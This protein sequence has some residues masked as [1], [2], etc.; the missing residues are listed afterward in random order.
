MK[1]LYI[2][3]KFLTFPG[4]Y[5]RSFWE[6]LICRCIKVT[7][8]PTGYLRADEACGHV[9]HGLAKKPFGAYILA[10]LPGFLTF[11]MGLAFFLLGFMNLEY[12]GI[13]FYDSKP[14]FIAYAVILYLGISLLCSVFPLCE[15]ILNYW[16]MAYSKTGKV[17]AHGV[18]RVFQ[19][20]FRIIVFIPA[21]ITRIGAFLERYCI[22]FLLWVAFVVLMIVK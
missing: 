21:L 13:T 16:D 18:L 11:N 9:E 4:A 2:I 3:S 12:M 14:L 1:I 7:I 8:E 22:I 15:D 10:T 6:H 5:I 19:F 20:I 17:K